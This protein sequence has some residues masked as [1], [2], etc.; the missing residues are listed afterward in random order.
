MD[1]GTSLFISIMN[2]CA[3]DILVHMQD[4]LQVLLQLGSIS[5]MS[6]RKPK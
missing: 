3:M 6:D 1:F 4:S 2:H 5:A